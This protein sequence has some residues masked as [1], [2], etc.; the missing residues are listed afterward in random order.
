MSA[1]YI[2]EPIGP[3]TIDRA[4]PLARACGYAL[5]LREWQALCQRLTSAQAGD[6]SIRDGKRALVA[7]DPQGYVKGL[8]IYATRADSRYGRLFDVPIFVVVSAV[9]PHGVTT[10]L[11]RALRSECEQSNC[12]GIRFWPMRADAWMGRQ[13]LDAIGRTDHRLFLRP[14]ASVTA[15][16]EA[17]SARTFGSPGAMD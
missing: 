9:D 5:T 1:C 3:P 13:S 4:Y 12:S 6:E 7:R 2:V 10:Q 14:L 11:V 17:V 15:M 16:E 8:S